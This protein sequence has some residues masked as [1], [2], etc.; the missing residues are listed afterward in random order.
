MKFIISILLSSMMLLGCALQNDVRILESRLIA[1]ENRNRDLQAETVI[2]SYSIHYTKLYD[3]IAQ[4]VSCRPKPGGLASQ[5]L[6]F[7][8]KILVISFKLGFYGG[9][10]LPDP[11]YNF[12]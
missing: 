11:S 8:L 3:F 9:F 5:G 6:V 2:T 7:F 1:L 12:V 4:T 10:F